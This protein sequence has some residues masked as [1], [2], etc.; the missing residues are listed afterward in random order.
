MFDFSDDRISEYLQ[1]PLS[2]SNQNINK[3]LIISNRFE[4]L[5]KSQWRI[6]EVVIQLQAEPK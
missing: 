4:K 2:A 6:F 3:H 1:M 5:V